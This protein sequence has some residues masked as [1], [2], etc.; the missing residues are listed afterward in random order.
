[1]MRRCKSLCTPKTRSALTD[2]PGEYVPYVMRAQARRNLQK[3][4]PLMPFD[5]DTFNFNVFL[6]WLTRNSPYTMKRDALPEMICKVAASIADEGQ[7]HLESGPASA[8]TQLIP[9]STIRA[10][11]QG[12]VQTPAQAAAAGAAA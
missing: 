12:C 9:A 1:M 10:L 5:C 2:N 11:A 6:T 3:V 8:E 4:V 7:A